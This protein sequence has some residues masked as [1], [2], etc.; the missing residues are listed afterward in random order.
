MVE[1]EHDQSDVK[2]NNIP[3]RFTCS[4]CAKSCP[5]HFN[6]IGVRRAI[7]DDSLWLILTALSHMDALNRSGAAAVPAFRAHRHTGGTQRGL[8]IQL[9]TFSWFRWKKI[10]LDFFFTLTANKP[11]TRANT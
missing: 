3:V 8:W 7:K 11:P 2:N 9:Q 10:L 4:F 6:F 1:P 5:L